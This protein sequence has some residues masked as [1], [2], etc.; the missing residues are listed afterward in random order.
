M[1]MVLFQR[2]HYHILNTGMSLMIFT[3]LVEIKIRRNA[4]AL[5]YTHSEQKNM[6]DEISELN[7]EEK[8]VLKP[9]DFFSKKGNQILNRK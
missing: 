1:V 9:K 6:H 7:M 5:N 2:H 3:A 8:A 4:A